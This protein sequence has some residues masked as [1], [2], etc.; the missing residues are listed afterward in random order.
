MAAWASSYL[1]NAKMQKAYFATCQWAARGLP[2]AFWKDPLE[3]YGRL[4]K[5]NIGV[6][7]GLYIGDVIFRS[8]QGFGLLL[9][10]AATRVGHRV[11]SFHI[12]FWS[13]RSS[14][15]VRVLGRQR[16]LSSSVC[17]ATLACH[18]LAM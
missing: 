15:S 1:A 16:S 9:T 6:I 17:V 8:S 14:E 10:T 13:H 3:P 5:E 12:G 2:G 7:M 4:Y 18:S 11:Q